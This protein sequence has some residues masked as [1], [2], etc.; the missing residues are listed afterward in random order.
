MQGLK[1][2][3]EHKAMQVRNKERSCVCLFLYWDNCWVVIS[4]RKAVIQAAAVES[5]FTVFLRAVDHV[6]ARYTVS[7]CWCH[8]CHREGVAEG[9]VSCRANSTCVSRCTGWLKRRH[10]ALICALCS[11]QA[12]C[13]D[14]R[15]IGGHSKENNAAWAARALTGREGRKK[16]LMRSK[17]L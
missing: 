6:W 15:V 8:H 1:R 11:S 7:C 3:A 2:G 10:D 5:T 16:T 12:N 17:C 4:R 13:E 14:I 9:V